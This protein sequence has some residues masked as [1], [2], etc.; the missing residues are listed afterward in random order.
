MKAIRI[1]LASVSSL[2]VGGLIGAGVALLYAP[3]SGRATR[4]MLYGKGVVIRERALEEVNLS[5]A[6]AMAKLN[7]TSRQIQSQATHLSNQL[8]DL[9]DDQQTALKEV[10]SSIPLPFQHNGH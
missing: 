1:L 2:L 8:Q 6:K 7:K 10:V 4:T 5:R 3:Q 9:V